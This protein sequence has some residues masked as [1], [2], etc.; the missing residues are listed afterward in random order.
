MREFNICHL[1]PANQ[2][3]IL[4]TLGSLGSGWLKIESVDPKE[5]TDPP[6]TSAQIDE[7]FGYEPLGIGTSSSTRHQKASPHRISELLSM[8]KTCSMGQRANVLLSSGAVSVVLVQACSIF[9]HDGPKIL[10]A[11]DEQFESMSEVEINLPISEYAQPYPVMYVVMPKKWRIDLIHRLG[12][13]PVNCPTGVLIF[14]RK[15]NQGKN[16]IFAYHRFVEEDDINF[17][18]F[19]D[20]NSFKSIEDGIT[21]FSDDNKTLHKPNDAHDHFCHISLRACLNLL[22]L[23]MNYK[24]STEKLPP[25]RRPKNDRFHTADIQAF[26]IKQSIILREAAPPIHGDAV[27]EP[28]QPK[29]IEMHPH[30]RRG[31]WRMQ[32]CGIGNTQR[33]RTLIRPMFIRKD[34]LIGNVGDTGAEYQL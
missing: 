14:H 25:Q 11:N 7:D 18:I 23:M 28:G 33:R 5:S 1:I 2:H 12:L 13:D 4:R 3:E 8:L 32:P 6:R 17:T 19:Q 24:D 9:L 22:I 21:S 20:S 27:G 34:R 16:F 29:H 10:Y 31:H 26:E 15:T 30:W